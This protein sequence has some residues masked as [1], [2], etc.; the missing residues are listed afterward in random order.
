MKTAT[1]DRLKNDLDTVLDWVAHG[2]PVRISKRGRVVAMLTPAASQPS[3]AAANDKP[4]G[5]RPDFLARLKH[6][7][8]DKVLP[9]NIVLQAREEERY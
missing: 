2:E 8:G 9:G 1:I 4:N 3:H 7:F 5:K 6:T